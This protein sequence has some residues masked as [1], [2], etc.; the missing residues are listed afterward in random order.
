MTKVEARM[1]NEARNPKLEVAR[2]AVWRF[3]LPASSF[4]SACF[5][6]RHSFISCCFALALAWCAPSVGAEHTHHRAGHPECVAHYAQ[7]S[8]HYTGSYVGGG[9]AFH[10]CARRP[11]EGTW[12]W[13]YCGA[14]LRHR[15]WLGWCHGRRCQG[16][17]GAYKTDGPHVPDPIGRLGL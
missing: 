5:D 11:D 9:C 14:I 10:G 12:G 1:S 6:I 8:S 17:S 4:F 7:R 15:P 16:G 2:A 13:D 3:G